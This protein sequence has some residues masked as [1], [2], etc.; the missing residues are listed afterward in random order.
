MLTLLLLTGALFFVPDV[1][2]KDSILEGLL[3]KHEMLE[4]I[5]GEKIIFIGGSN[6]SFGLDSKK[7]IEKFSKPVV[8]MGVHANLGLEFTI[9]DVKSYINKGDVVVLAPEYE[10]FYTDDFYG[11]MEL[12]SVLFDID[13]SGRKLVDL[14]QWRHLF[15]Y[16]PT[17]SAKK[18]KN[19]IFSPFEKKTSSSIISPYDRK[20]FNEFGDTYIHWSL[21]NQS[22]L[23]SKKTNGSEKINTEVMTF[24]KN[25]KEYTEDRQA[26]LIILPPVI[27]SQ[28]YDSLTNVIDLIN[29]SLSSNSIPYSAEPV[30][31]KFS[32]DLFFNT[33]YHLNKKGVD[34]RTQLVIEDL[35]NIVAGGKKP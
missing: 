29:K 20:S 11:M 19:Y 1:I 32:S 4:R 34:K 3:D 16:I 27:E 25:F 23:C 14:T 9:N 31:Y 8:N 33:Y 24:L 7:V 35:N 22:H 17:Y 21:P 30:R 12:V 18:I 28:S 2:S 13:P 15:K 6:I 10:N 26:K 5:N